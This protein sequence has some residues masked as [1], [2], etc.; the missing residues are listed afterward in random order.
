MSFTPNIPTI[1]MSLGTSRVAIVNN[2]SNLYNT[3]AV[4]HFEG[5]T[6]VAPPLAPGKHKYVQMPTIPN[7]VVASAPTNP[8]D[9]LS[10]YTK[11][12]S[13]RSTL[14]YKKDNSVDEWQLT[15]VDPSNAN[16]GYTFLPGG[17]LIQWGVNT[18]TTAAGVA[19]TVSFPIAFNNDFV[20]VVTLCA[21]KAAGSTNDSM[22]YFIQILASG[23][24][25]TGFQCARTGT[26]ITQVNWMV[27][28]AKA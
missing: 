6:V 28:G 26:S 19:R 24:T 20:P 7:A 27:V 3:S 1:N 16:P 15:G 25:Y 8:A 14:Y 21:V 13:G 18:I 23:S 10:L 4:N 11:S 2:F 9:Q 22:V 5:N 12:V 17:L